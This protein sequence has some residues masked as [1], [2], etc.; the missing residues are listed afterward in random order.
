MTDDVD[1]APTGSVDADAAAPRGTPLEELGVL[2][3]QEKEIAPGLAH[4]EIY[5][6]KG[7]LT[8]MWHGPRDA[9]SALVAGGGAAGG[10]L[11][12]ASGLYHDLGVALAELGIATLRVGWRRPDDIPMCSHDMA[13][14]CEMAAV[15]GTRRFVT[16]GHSFGGAIAVRVGV[17]FPRLVRGVV[18]LATQSA[19]CEHAAGLAERP[20]LLIHGENDELLPPHVS[21]TVHMLAGGHGELVI[22]PG[23]G[24][25]LSEVG[26]E[27]RARLVEWIPAT[28]AH[29]QPAQPEPPES[30]G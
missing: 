30:G 11:G 19:G 21:E 13:A 14:A 29:D 23:T 9:P 22:L 7:L 17:A 2:A 10:L 26:D 3:I 27:L 1:A 6:W 25:L 15:R 8:L 24:H 20:F 12:P 18:T 28:L 4:L 16:M 5:T